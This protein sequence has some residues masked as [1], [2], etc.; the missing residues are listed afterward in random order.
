[1]LCKPGSDRCY[2]LIADESFLLVCE[3]G[4]NGTD[5]E[6]IAYKKRI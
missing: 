4:E 3:Y 6:L 5:A 2:G 1:M